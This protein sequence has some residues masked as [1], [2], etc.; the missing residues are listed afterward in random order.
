VRVL[1]ATVVVEVGIDVPDAT[2]AVVLA[3]D[4][5][6]LSQLHQIRGRVGRR[7][8]PAA[9]CSSPRSGARRAR[10]S[11]PS[12]RPT[13]ASALRGARL[14]LRGP[15]ELLGARQHGIG[16]AAL[17]RGAHRCGADRAVARWAEL[18]DEGADR[19]KSRGGKPFREAGRL[20]APT[21]IW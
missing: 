15:G 11:T 4:R 2:L 7:G 5:F 12:R 21:A 8:A 10:G 19:R 13:T 17:S 20:P 1:V 14:T 6:G 18:G 16:G 3:A 9:A